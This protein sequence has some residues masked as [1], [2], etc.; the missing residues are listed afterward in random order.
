MVSFTGSTTAGKRVSEVAAR[1]V[2]R[3]ALELGGK[4][5]NV[6][7][8]DADL[9]KAVKTGVQNCDFN[10]GQTCSAWTRM[11]VPRAKHDEAARIAKQAAESFTPGNSNT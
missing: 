2:K 11:L 8:D 3:V 5:A 10:S 6:I 9:A 7:L 1:T 4:S